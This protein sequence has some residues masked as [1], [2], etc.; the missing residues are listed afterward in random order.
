MGEPIPESHCDL[1]VEP[2][3]GVLTTVMPDGQPQNSIVWTDYDGQHVLV[4]T[5]LE[6]QKGRNMRANPRVTLLVIDPRDGS[7]WI[8][9]RG[10]VVEMTAEG[11]EAH[12]DRL[13]RLYTGKRHF[14]G[15][16]YPVEQRE[17]ETRVIVKILPLKVAVDAIFR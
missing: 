15:D 10:T 2:V 12:A 8:E 6:R 11:A 7:R 5:T 3:H 9:V 16:I 14:Y 17:R 1:L 13:T 4:N